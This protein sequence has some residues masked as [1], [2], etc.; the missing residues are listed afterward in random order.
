M[1]VSL[2]QAHAAFQGSGQ[3]TWYFLVRDTSPTSPLLFRAH[4]D[5]TEAWTTAR[6]ARVAI[7]CGTGPRIVPHFYLTA[8]LIPAGSQKVGI[9]RSWGEW[10]LSMPVAWADDRSI[11]DVAVVVANPSVILIDLNTGN[12]TA[13]EVSLADLEDY[14]LSSASEP[15][16]TEPLLP[17][18][19]GE[20][21]E[22]AAHSEVRTGE[23]RTA[24][25]GG[26]RPA[27]FSSGLDPAE[28]RQES[29]RRLAA[30]SNGQT[31]SA[32]AAP[33]IQDGVL[34]DAERTAWETAAAARRASILQQPVTT[35]VVE[36]TADN[37]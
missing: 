3:P 12:I 27:A 5:P 10:L 30:S 16:S 2:A 4:R 23:D 36:P 17:A 19:G 26:G 31:D 6:A 1:A 11:V 13:H 15:A 28:I 20:K 24:T 35:F 14:F 18:A 8:D 9:V 29:A 37:A 25:H 22:P 7:D 21:L 33:P 34:T 32:P